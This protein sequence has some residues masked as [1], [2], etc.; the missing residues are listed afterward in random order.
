MITSKSLRSLFLWLFLESTG[1]KCDPLSR[2]V[3]KLLN[4]RYILILPCEMLWISNC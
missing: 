2:L 4:Q 1:W 3:A